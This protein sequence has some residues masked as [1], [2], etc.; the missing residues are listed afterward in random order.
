M[1]V[2]SL[3]PAHDGLLSW[4]ARRPRPVSSGVFRG[5]PRAFHLSGQGCTPRAPWPVS[6]RGA[7]PSNGSGRQLPWTS[8]FVSLSLSPG[9]GFCKG[10]NYAQSFCLSITYTYI[11]IYTSRFGLPPRSTGITKDHWQVSADTSRK[12]SL[13]TAESARRPF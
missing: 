2:G 11:Y 7:P 12:K 13:P 8:L 10:T 4:R 6:V 1:R 3:V 5:S 9:K